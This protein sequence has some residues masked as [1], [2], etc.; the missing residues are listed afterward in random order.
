MFL[1][2][3]LQWVVHY[4]PTLNLP[5]HGDGRHYDDDDDD[6]NEDQAENGLVQIL[7]HTGDT[8][9]RLGFGRRWDLDLFNPQMSFFS[10]ALKDGDNIG[11]LH[12]LGKKDAE[13]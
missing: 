13:K 1:L 6:A 12:L 8:E 2:Q 4:Q 11:H 9:A 5:F 3:T 10:P 7:G